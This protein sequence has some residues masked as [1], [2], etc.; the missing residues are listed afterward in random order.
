MEDE[1]VITK[2]LSNGAS[3]YDIVASRSSGI[4]TYEEAFHAVTNVSIT[5]QVI[6]DMLSEE[7]MSNAVSAE[8]SY[9]KY[10][11]EAYEDG[12]LVDKLVFICRNR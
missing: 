6:Q 12:L 10:N 8:P 3:G 11:F 4:L 1:S 7:G 5:E 2:V 9:H